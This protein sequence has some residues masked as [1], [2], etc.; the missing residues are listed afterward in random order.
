[1]PEMQSDSMVNIDSKATSL[2]SADLGGYKYAANIRA[3]FKE[4]VSTCPLT[5]V[6]RARA[7]K[8]EAEK[9]FILF[10]ADETKWLSFAKP[11]RRSWFDAIGGS[12]DDLHRRLE[13]DHMA[14]YVA[15]PLDTEVPERFIYEAFPLMLR[16]LKKCYVPE[17]L[18]QQQA[19]E[20]VS[21]YAK[22]T[23]HKYSI[24]FKLRSVWFNAD[25]TYLEALRRPNYHLTKAWI[26]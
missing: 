22:E 20:Y 4:L 13:L 21:S 14:F 15:L 3:Y 23:N 5:S 16:A 11:I 19:I 24:H 25:G 26:M 6:E 12:Y 10:D 7:S 18:T 17:G 9:T 1:M 2:S 8:F